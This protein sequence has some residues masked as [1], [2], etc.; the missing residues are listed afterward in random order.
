MGE[1]PS[2]SGEDFSLSVSDIEG[3]QG[4]RI[5]GKD[6]FFFSLDP[7]TPRILEPKPSALAEGI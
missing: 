7:L 5:Q 1:N 2:P 3:F 6:W 4:S